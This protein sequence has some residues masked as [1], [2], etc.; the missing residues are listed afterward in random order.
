MGFRLKPL[1]KQRGHR[2]GIGVAHRHPTDQEAE[3]VH[4]VAKERILKMS[5]HQWPKG[6]G[7]VSHRPEVGQQLPPA[8]QQLGHPVHT[9][10][11]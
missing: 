4:P 6:A 11:H 10:T 7:E 9:R 5:I 1:P 2:G 8:L 3:Q